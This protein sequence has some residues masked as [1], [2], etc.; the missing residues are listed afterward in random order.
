MEIACA[1]LSINCKLAS[2][3]GFTY[4]NSTDFGPK[5]VF[6]TVFIVRGTA[7]RPEHILLGYMDLIPYRTLTGDPTIRNAIWVPTLALNP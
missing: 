4:P 3:R 6:A 1:T 7:L 2:P 5:V